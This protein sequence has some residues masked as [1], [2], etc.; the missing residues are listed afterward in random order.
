MEP[1]F[2][3]PKALARRQALGLFVAVTPGLPFYSSSYTA[4]SRVT[5]HVP[6]ISLVGCLFVEGGVKIEMPGV[7]AFCYFPGL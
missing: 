7:I 3:R 4:L 5:L 2:S 1:E 6:K